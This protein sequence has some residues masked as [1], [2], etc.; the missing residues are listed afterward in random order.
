[1]PETPTLDE[2]WHFIDNIMRPHELVPDRSALSYEEV[3]SVYS[4]LCEIDEMFRE[5][6]QIKI[7][8]KE[9]NEGENNS[10]IV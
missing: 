9:L 2:M 1:L 3:F 7:F 8:K 10:V 4:K 5:I 6:E